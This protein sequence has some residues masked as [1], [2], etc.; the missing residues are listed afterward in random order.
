VADDE[1]LGEAAQV[2]DLVGR[3]PTLVQNATDSRDALISARNWLVRNVPLAEAGEI[4]VVVLGSYARLEA[5]GASDF[6]YLVVPHALPSDV[7]VGRRLLETTDSYIRQHLRA[8]R[9]GKTGMFG[10]ITGASDLTERI[11]LEQDTNLSHSRRILIVQESCSVYRPDLHEKLL[12][13]IFARYLVDYPSGV[14]AGPPRF[15]LND[16]LRYWYTIAVD[17]QAKRWEDST[18][19]WGLR[20]LKLLNSRKIAYAGALV[21]LLRCDE[22][23]P[24]TV[25]YLL[26]EFMST[27]L[28][29]LGRLALDDRFSDRTALRSVFLHAEAFAAFLADGDGRAIINK[30]RSPEEARSVPQFQK[31]RDSSDDLA[32]ALCRVF[33]D[34]YLA[35]RSRKYLVF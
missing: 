32:T 11:G 4:D 10:R 13:A 1:L 23:E 17:Y 26:R 19:G 7:R 29:R 18:G 2:L 15:L 33:F 28:M 6:D 8:K 22:D 24:A 14:K 5:S 31:L 30:I 21:T 12:R 25:D 34:S 16:V 3:L 9:P 20:Y 35:E 27:P